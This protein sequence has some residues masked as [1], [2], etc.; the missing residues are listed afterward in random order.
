MGE[1]NAFL[2]QLDI[3]HSYVGTQSPV[4]EKTVPTSLERL[5][6]IQGDYSEQDNW[7]GAPMEQDLE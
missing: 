4:I 7:A 2:N 5:W 1:D 3:E 6:A